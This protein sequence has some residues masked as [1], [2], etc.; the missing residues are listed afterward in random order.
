MGDHWRPKGALQ[1]FTGVSNSVSK[2]W[3]QFGYRNVRYWTKAPRKYDVQYLVVG[4]GGGGGNWAGGGGAGGGGV[5]EGVVT[6]LEDVWY[7]VNIGG[8]GTS[9]G[10][11]ATPTDGTLSRLYMWQTVKASQPGQPEQAGQNHVGVIVCPGGGNGGAGGDPPTGNTATPGDGGCGGGASRRFTPGGLGNEDGGFGSGTVKTDYIQGYDGGD[12]A[13]DGISADFAGG[14]GGSD[15]AGAN[16]DAS[17]SGNGGNGGAGKSSSITG[18]AVN[19]GGGG[20]GGAHKSGATGGL[21]GS[22]GGGNANSGCTNASAGAVNT[23]GG[24]GGASGVRGTCGVNGGAGGSGKVVLRIPTAQ[25]QGMTQE[26]VVGLTPTTT[27]S[28]AY[29]ILTFNATGVFTYKYNS[30]A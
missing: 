29:T 14:G 20:G 10:Q 3:N 8:G 22:G 21:G 9:G 17:G 4:G 15:A 1:G 23:G 7:V 6:F 5:Q 30:R 28:G 24:G 25:I 11:L 26:S 2:W 19:Y 16:G 27:T 18:S 13:S 12:R